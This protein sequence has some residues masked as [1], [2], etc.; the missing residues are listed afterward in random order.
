MKEI[1]YVEF[2]KHGVMD[3]RSKVFLGFRISDLKLTTNNH[4]QNS[5]FIYTTSAISYTISRPFELEILSR[6][7]KSS[8]S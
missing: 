7:T 6:H 3:N 2:I 8:D 4:R 1:E 5:S